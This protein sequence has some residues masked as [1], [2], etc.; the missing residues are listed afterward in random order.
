MMPLQK[1]KSRR[2]K[3]KIK[4]K[5]KKINW[6][7]EQTCKYGCNQESYEDEALPHPKVVGKELLVW[8]L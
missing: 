2:F 8:L 6:S 3:E 5:S 4:G 1:M 7:E